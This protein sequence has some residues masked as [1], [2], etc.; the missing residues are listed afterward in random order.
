VKFVSPQLILL[1]RPVLLL[2][3]RKSLLLASPPIAVQNANPTEINRRL[4]EHKIELA[5][6]LLNLLGD[7]FLECFVGIEKAHT[8]VFAVSVV[9]IG[10]ASHSKSGFEETAHHEGGSRS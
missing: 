6:A 1:V 4:V 7:R 5:R 10:P 8:G 9:D 2:L 3:L